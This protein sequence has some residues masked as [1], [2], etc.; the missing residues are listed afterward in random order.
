MRSQDGV[1][2]ILDA[3][4][5]LAWSA[6]PDFS[7]EFINRHW[8]DFAGVSADEAPDRVWTDAVHPDDRNRLADYWRSLLTSGEPGEI[9]AR[10]RR[11]DGEYRRFLLRASP[12]RDELGNVVK[13]YG[14]NTDIEDRKRAE[15][16]LQ[17]DEL[18]FRDIVNSIPAFVSTLT[19]CGEIEFVNQ[20]VLDYFGKTLEEL[21]DWA[22]SDVVHP[23]DLPEVVSTWSAAI[24]TGVPNEVQLRLRRADGVLSGPDTWVTV[25][26]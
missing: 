3:I 23:D 25:C 7:P 20:P 21:K 2:T 10:L 16:V 26:S 18:S 4:P 8:L 22:V 15:E 13:W 12:F 5:A 1:R 6:R 14:T 24:E 19:P 17:T 9:E 11:F